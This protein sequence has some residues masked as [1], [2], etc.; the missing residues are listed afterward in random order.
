M[1]VLRRIDTSLLIHY[2][3]TGALAS[4][5]S[6]GCSSCLNVSLT[7]AAPSNIDRFLIKEELSRGQR[8]RAF[9]I[10]ADGVVVYNGTAVGRT[11][12]AKLDKNLSAV[13][14]V[15]LVV[16][17]SV[18]SPSFRLFAVPD[19]SVCSAGGGGGGNKCELVHDV[20]YVGPYLK[21]LDVADVQA[22]C[23]ACKV[24]STCSVFAATPET[25]AQKKWSCMLADAARGEKAHP[26]AVSGSPI[27]VP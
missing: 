2:I 16:R 6:G 13:K 19:P 10:H 15:T 8:V 14:V 11:L 21:S 24:T 5:V 22:C 26:G 25:A 12:I 23:D 17:E 9:E 27:R 3:I 20:V 1:L 18:G 7:L 4:T